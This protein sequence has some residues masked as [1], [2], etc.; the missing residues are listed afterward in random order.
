M[1]IDPEV[2]TGPYAH[3]ESRSEEVRFASSG[4]LDRSFTVLIADRYLPDPSNADRTGIAVLDN[5]NAKVV[6]DGLCAGNA[7]SSIP[8]VFRFADLTSMKWE[9]FAEMCRTNPNYRGGIPDIDTPTDLPDPG[10][11]DR[12]SA[13]GLTTTKDARSEFIKSLSQDPELPYIFPHADRDAMEADICR[14]FMYVDPVGPWRHIGWDIRMN[15]GWNRTGRLKGGADLNSQ[16]DADW[17]HTV[18]ND[19]SVT[20]NA[21][22]EFM[23]PYLSG[24]TGILD[25]DEFP[26]EF[27][28]AGKNNG[29]L[30][31]KKFCGF[32]MGATQDMSIAD[33]ILKLT[34]DRL[35]ALWVACRVL[36]EDLS[37]DNR[38]RE[39]EQQM[40]LARVAFENPFIPANA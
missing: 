2:Q 28:L 23:A 25:M 20:Q 19:P 16:F 12:Q 13:L 5:D 34:D 15:M 17:R 18:E 31:L 24:P 6:F 38:R 21:S 8:M 27:E 35:E 33:R 3:A 39:M 36:D 7:A 10:N 32:H 26:C 22:R 11:I 37:P 14:H 9:A 1:P 40:H 30:I 29:F 4:D